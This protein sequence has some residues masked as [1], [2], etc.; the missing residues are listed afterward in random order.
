MT[1]PLQFLVGMW[2][3]LTGEIAFAVGMWIGEHL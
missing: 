1:G 3:V 2:I